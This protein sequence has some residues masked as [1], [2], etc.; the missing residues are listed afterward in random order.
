MATFL[1][2][3]S[4]TSAKYRGWSRPCIYKP[5]SLS[6]LLLA[7]W[8]QILFSSACTPAPPSCCSVPHQ[9]YT[10]LIQE[11]P[12]WYVPNLRSC[13]LV[14]LKSSNGVATFHRSSVRKPWAMLTLSSFQPLQVMNHKIPPGTSSI[15][16]SQIHTLVSP[17]MT[18]SQ[19]SLHHLSPEILS[20]LCSLWPLI[21]PRDCPKH[22]ATSGPVLSIPQNGKWLHGTLLHRH[23]KPWTLN[24]TLGNPGEQTL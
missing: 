8:L 23:T 9:S 20:F 4:Q 1:S 17:P 15:S 11:P 13:L 18:G 10:L 22:T 2:P 19:L 3:L 7:G 12:P 14:M 6:W 24:S 16:S 21:C 5:H